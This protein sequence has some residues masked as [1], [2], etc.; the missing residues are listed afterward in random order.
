MRPGCRVPQHHALRRQGEPVSRAMFISLWGTG[1][2]STRGTRGR[3][4]GR[5]SM[6]TS[7]TPVRLLAAAISLLAVFILARPAQA[8]QAD[9]CPGALDVPD[10]PAAAAQAADAVGCL[11]NAE[12]TSRGLQP[13]QRDGD[14]A[15]AGRKH[16]SD[17]VR[18]NYF[19]HVSPGGTDP[20]DRA[21]DAG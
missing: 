1:L 15:Q 18:R 9:R 8:A 17:M 13:L 19:S 16:A 10:S 12:R 6:Y 3:R 11:V 5:G 7:A 2:E 4:A 20:G 21:V 14:L